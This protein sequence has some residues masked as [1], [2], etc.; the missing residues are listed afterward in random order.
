MSGNGKVFH[1]EKIDIF[2]FIFL[3]L[4]STLKLPI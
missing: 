2:I 1:P 3:S 4:K